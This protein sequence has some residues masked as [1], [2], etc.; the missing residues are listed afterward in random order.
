MRFEIFPSI[1]ILALAQIVK[2]SCFSEATLATLKREMAVLRS[3]LLQRRLLQR[4][5]R[6]VQKRNRE[7]GVENEKVRLSLV[8]A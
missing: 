5:L 3:S 8:L 6:T 1:K 4:W 2:V 7:R